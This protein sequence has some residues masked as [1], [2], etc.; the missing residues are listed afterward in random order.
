MSQYSGD[1]RHK[2]LSDVAIYRTR[3]Q[4]LA[5]LFRHAWFERVACASVHKWGRIIITK[6]Y[7][8]S[9]YW[10]L[11]GGMERVE[12]IRIDAECLKDR[13]IATSLFFC[14]GYGTDL[15]MDDARARSV[16]GVCSDQ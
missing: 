14:E 11:S 4:S 3:K 5:G 10:D 13:M 15:R 1:L 9:T 2:I 7:C 8:A 6:I 16:P 12:L